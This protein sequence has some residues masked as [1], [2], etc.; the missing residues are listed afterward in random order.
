MLGLNWVAGVI[1][2]VL[3]VVIIWLL[4]RVYRSF[5]ERRRSRQIDWA[6]RILDREQGDRQPDDAVEPQQPD[7]NPTDHPRSD[8]S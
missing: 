1:L 2:L 4:R 8:P 7:S 3:L 6:T 5:A